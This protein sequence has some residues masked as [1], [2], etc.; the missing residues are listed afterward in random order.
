M[1]SS[2]PKG[3]TTKW[4]S[5]LTSSFVHHVLINSHRQSEIMALVCPQK[6]PGR[7]HVSKNAMNWFRTCSILTYL[8]HGVQSF[9]RS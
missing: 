9:L 5:D 1:S 3:L 4:H 6:A 7:Y 2:K 8:L